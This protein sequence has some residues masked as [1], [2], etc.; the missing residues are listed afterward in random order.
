MDA[1]EELKNRGSA[2]G[3][4]SGPGLKGKGMGE[5][6]RELWLFRGGPAPLLQHSGSPTVDSDEKRQSMVFRRLL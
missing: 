5:E 3:V 4:G 6:E 1:M 2:P